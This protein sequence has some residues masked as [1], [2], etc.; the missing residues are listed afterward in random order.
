M[1][2]I[3]EYEYDWGI[4]ARVRQNVNKLFTVDITGLVN[5]SKLDGGDGGCLEQLFCDIAP[6][7]LTIQH[8]ERRNKKR[9][10]KVWYKS[11]DSETVE[12]VL[13]LVTYISENIK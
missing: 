8:Y 2:E 6:S 13:N 5:V 7:Q 4:K 12:K 9:T 3:T 10:T 1:N 11:I